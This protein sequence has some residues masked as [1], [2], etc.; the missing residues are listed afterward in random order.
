VSR[1]C[2]GLQARAAQAIDG[3]PWDVDRKARQQGGHPADVAVVFACLIRTAED[4]VVE[5]D[6]VEPWPIHD[7]SQRDR[8]KIVGAD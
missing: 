2:H 8:C 1:R 7:R 4:D 6:G 5:L 3:L